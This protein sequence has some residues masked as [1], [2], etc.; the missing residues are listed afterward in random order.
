MI[1]NYSSIFQSA[2][3]IIFQAVVS[4]L[5]QS[6]YYFSQHSWFASLIVIWIF[7]P[8][9]QE[10]FSVQGTIMNQMQPPQDLF[11]ISF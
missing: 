7:S 11:I 2:Q 4:L 8:R 5:H 6:Q 9:N 1:P 10:I 3:A